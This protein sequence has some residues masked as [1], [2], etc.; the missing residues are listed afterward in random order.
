MVG[1]QAWLRGLISPLSCTQLTL[2]FPP[3]V[4]TCQRAGSSAV[5]WCTAPNTCVRARFKNKWSRQSCRT[6]EVHTADVLKVPLTV[7]LSEYMIVSRSIGAK[8]QRELTK[9][10]LEYLVSGGG[11]KHQ[12][13]IWDSPKGREQRQQPLLR[14]VS[15]VQLPWLGVREFTSWAVTKIEEM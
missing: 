4:R 15:K 9:I 2:V 6:N 10:S 7:I 11:R 3:L 12:P 8:W 13:S 1:F 5:T 14:L